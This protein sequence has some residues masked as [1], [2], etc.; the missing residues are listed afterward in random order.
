MSIQKDMFGLFLEDEDLFC[1]QRHGEAGEAMTG[2][3]NP[4][5]TWFLPFSPS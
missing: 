4:D 2:A 3:M 1:E 5:A